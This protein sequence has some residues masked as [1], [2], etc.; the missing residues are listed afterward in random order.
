MMPN[1]D[2]DGIRKIINQF[3]TLLSLFQIYLP[4][5]DPDLIYDLLMRLRDNP[6]ITPIYTLEVYTGKEVDLTRTIDFIYKI[7]G[8]MAMVYD[9]NTHYVTNQKLSLVMLKK[10]SDMDGVIEITGAHTTSGCWFSDA[11]KRRDI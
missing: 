9:D 11:I 5:V 3:D 1:I 2:L 4:N 10:I 7:T 6:G 8:A